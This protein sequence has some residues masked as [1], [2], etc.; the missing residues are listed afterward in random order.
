MN[1]QK[2]QPRE[3]LNKAFLKINPFRKD[4]ETFKKHLKNLIAKINESESEEFHKNLI[5]DF[6]K[7]TYYSSNHFI[8][9]KGR[10]DLV[11][12]NGQD[13]KT[14]VGVIL[15][16]KKPT[17]KSEMLKVDNLNTKAF[18]ELVLYFLRERLTEKNLELKYLIATN[19]Y[20]WFI[21]DAQDFDK[22]FQ[23]NKTLV[24][25]FKDFTDGRLISKKTDFFDQEIAQPAIME[26]ADKITFT[27]FDIREYQEYLQPGENPDDHKL[28]GLF[29]LLSPEHLLKL[30]F[31]NDSNTLDKGFYHELL[32][33]IGLIEVKEGGKK[34]IQ[35][36]K[37]NERNIGSLMENAMIQLDSLD[38]ISQLKEP[39]QFGETYQL[40]LFNVGL[41]LAITWVNRIL[42][43]KLL[44]AQL[45]KY[46]QNDLAWGFLNL[47]KVQNYDDLNSLFFSVLARK[48]EDRN[49]GFKN[50]FAHVPYLNSSLFE[51]TEMEQATIFISNLR[52]EKLEIFS[53]TVLK[54]NKGKKRFGEINALEYLFEFLD[55]YDFSS[56][57]GEEIQEE[58][59]RLINA[60]VL[61]LIF[62]KINGYQDGSFFTPGFITMYMC[63]E[64]IRRAVVEKFNEIKGWNCE[65]IDDLYDRIEDKR[66]ANTIINSLKICDPA[67]GSGHFLVSALNEII[68]IKSELKI[69][70]DREGKRLKEYQIEV[71]NDELIVIDE[72]GLLF[73]YNPKSKES[74]RVQETLF[75]EKQRIIEGCLFGVDINSNSVKICQLRLWVELL[76]NAYYKTSPLTPLLQGEGNMRELET[77]PNIDI[78]IK[79][80]NSLISRF[81]LDSD[82]RPALNRSK[83]S[84]ESYR[85][86]V[87]TYRNAEN[88]EQKREMKKLIAD[89]KGNFKTTLG[90]SDINK[91]KLRRLEGEVENLQG[92]IFLIPETKA[93]RT[94]R[95][96]KIAKLNNEIDKLRV[97]IE[98]IENGR[99]YD[100]ALEWRFEFPEVLNKDKA[101]K[102][103]DKGDYW[104]ELRACDYYQ[105][106]EKPKIMYQ[107]FQTKSC[108]I[109]DEQGLY[110]NNSMWIIP[111]ADKILLA[112]LNSKMGWWLISK[113]CTAIQNGF[114][115]IW[116]YFGQIPISQANPKEG[117][118]ITSLVDQILTAKKSDPKADTTALETEIDQ[119]VYQLYELT[120]EEIQIIEG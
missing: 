95:E 116:K 108:F 63:R 28:I 1:S 90:L 94:K 24:Q 47:N 88:K 57:T 2:L 87:K 112:I 46:H 89:I 76:K 113:Y 13:P 107:I 34:L 51:P 102:R 81:A 5:A 10:N 35:R 45:I 109:Y 27:H 104:W 58:N 72:D 99:M 103:T 98:E 11:I 6:F 42:F 71:V 49:E 73:E 14:S 52:N 20:E 119:L 26:I 19:I 15:E 91:T 64:T 40:Q 33:I 70:L 55:A 23:E 66:D 69:L 86:A 117:E 74:Q 79:C 84:M 101:E 21:F 68:A 50:K 100:N 41:E 8:N 4:I 3:A 115:L 43:L 29:K 25:Q 93:E 118:V 59:K 54:D 37:S 17:N 85:N 36:K 44:E 31:A 16:F 96:K 65:N 97:E 61:G 106:F 53:A 105:E 22:F 67:V 48:P 83:Y 120:P 18:Q 39:E 60:S 114:Q 7:N 32:H 30:P 82:L 110:C 75:H 92:Q 12:H 80:G 9:T 38:K 62:E 78:N 56:E 111:K 77:L